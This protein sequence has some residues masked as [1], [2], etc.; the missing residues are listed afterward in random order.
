[1][2]EMADGTKEETQDSY[3][4][5]LGEEEGSQ[6]SYELPQSLEGQGVSGLYITTINQIE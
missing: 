3:L 2:F 6:E 5:T 4:T 1:M